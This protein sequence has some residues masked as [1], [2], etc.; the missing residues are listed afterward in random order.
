M[1][2]TERVYR[3]R[4]LGYFLLVVLVSL[5]FGHSP[6]TLAAKPS[7]LASGCGPLVVDSGVADA[8]VSINGFLNDQYQWYDSACRLRS[9]ALA[10]NDTSKGGNAKQFTYGLADGTTR[11]CLLYTSDA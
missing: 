10:L 1:K 3:R 8:G 7:G 9:V 2:N 5:S 4:N 11:T 6:V